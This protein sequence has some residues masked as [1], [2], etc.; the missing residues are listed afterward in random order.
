MENKKK[1]YTLELTAEEL[2]HVRP[3][4]TGKYNKYEEAYVAKVQALQEQAKSDREQSDLRL[5]WCADKGDM[6]AHWT[7]RD[8]HGSNAQWRCEA[9]AKLMS[10]APE[11]LEAVK[12]LYGLTKWSIE[13]PDNRVGDACA[14]A[15]RAL[16]KVETGVPE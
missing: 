11:L 12:A 8:A 4:L 15:R 14:L 7:V 1:T 13:A 2:E 6:R 10:A 3:F 16:R 5:P 9:A